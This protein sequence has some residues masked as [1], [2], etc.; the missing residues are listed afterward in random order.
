MDI[1]WLGHSCFKIAGK[2]TTIITDPFSPDSGYSLGSQ[3]ADIVTISHQHQDHSFAEVI[4]G[5]PRLVQG[6]GEYEIGGVLIVGVA[7]YHDTEKGAERGKNTLY[8]LEVD[9]ISVCHLGDL[10]HELTSEQIEEIDNVDVLLV[11]VGGMTTI[12]AAVAAKVV[13]QLEPGIVIPMHYKTAALKKELE[14]VDKFLNEIGANSITPQP[15]LSIGKS[16]LS[17]SLQVFLLD[18]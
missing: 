5:N 10:G 9:D 8:V 14:P 1:N 7:T 12:G 16:N 17:D 13:R 3:T 18:Y 6:P 15:K 11:P 4:G 2:Q